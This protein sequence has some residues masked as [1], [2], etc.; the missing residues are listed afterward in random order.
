ME[1]NFLSAFKR[2]ISTQKKIVIIPHR[3]P[4]G[5]ALGSAL[6][7]KHFLDAKK[8]KVKIV[9]PNDYPTFLKWLPGESDIIKFSKT[10]SIA[11]DKINNAELIFG[12]DFNSL[13]RIQDLSEIVRR[14]KVDKIMI[15]H[16]FL[17]KIMIYHHFFIKND[18][19]S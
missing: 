15:D 4:D 1:N 14:S 18:D 9:S 10:P 16:H 17:L 8:H 12:L 6:A 2:I 13:S 7:L 5:D 3:N 19:K 11:R